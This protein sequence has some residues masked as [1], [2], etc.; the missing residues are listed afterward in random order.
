[1]PQR[2][3]IE[4]GSRV[5]VRLN[6]RDRELICDHT[7]AD[8]ELTGRLNLAAVDGKHLVVQ[9]TLQDLEELIG[10]VAA[11]ANHTPSRKLQSE[12][13]RLFLRLQA[14]LDTYDELEQ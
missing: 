4:S 10:Y 6:P 13:D 1:M 3:L 14:V 7:L 11:E 8:P 9:Y 5:P 12:L 2:K